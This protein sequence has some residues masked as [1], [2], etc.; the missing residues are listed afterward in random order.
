MT[1]EVNSQDVYAAPE[2]EITSEHE[3]TA[4]FF[5]IHMTK[6][7]VMTIGT[8]GIYFL[9]W[10][11]KHWKVIKLANGLN[12]WP[13]PRTIFSLFYTHSLFS[14][15]KAG[16]DSYGDKHIGWSSASIATIF[17][18]AGLLGWASNA[19]PEDNLFFAV[20]S[21]ALAIVITI[22]Q[23]IVGAKAQKVANYAAGDEDGENNTSYSVG[24]IVWLVIGGLLWLI[25]IASVVILALF[26]TAFGSA[27]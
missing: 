14:R 8:M 11:W 13:I 7:Y 9:Y 16:A 1:A 22:V 19:F 18:V 3:A 27:F 20:A 12:I 23:A 21:M 15:F 26:G 17:I 10:F 25:T 6:F 24:N 5:T 2:A 4:E